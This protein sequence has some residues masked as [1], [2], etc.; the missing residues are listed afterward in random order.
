MSNSVFSETAF[1]ATL[2]W[3]SNQSDACLQTL[4]KLE[5]SGSTDLKVARLD[6][7]CHGSCS[8]LDVVRPGATQHL[9]R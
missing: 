6:T 3:L 9:R 4:E 5:S 8:Q 7:D 2:L 1:E